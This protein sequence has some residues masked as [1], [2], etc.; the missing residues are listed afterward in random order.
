MKVTSIV[1]TLVVVALHARLGSS[2]PLSGAL[3]V[4]LLLPLITRFRVELRGAAQLAF[5]VAAFGAALALSLTFA[6]RSAAQLNGLSAWWSSL[7]VA[8]VLLIASRAFVVAPLGGEALNLAIATFGL[9]ACGGT[10]SGALYPTVIVIFVAT[11]LLARRSASASPTPMTHLFREHGFAVTV[12]AA[13]SFGT[14][15]AL[16]SVLPTAHAWTIG[17]ILEARPPAVGVGGR[18]WLGSMRGLL[19]SPES[20]L[21]VRGDVEL[22]R[23]VVFDS[24]DLGRWSR[25][26]SSIEPLSTPRSLSGATVVE[27]ESIDRTPR[28][29][30]TALDAEEIALSSGV[31]R[32]DRLGNLEAVEAYPADRTFLR[33]GSSGLTS[34]APPGERDLRVPARTAGRLRALAQAWADQADGDDAKLHALERALLSEYRYSLDFERSP[35]RDPIEEFLFVS[36]RGHCEYFASAFALLA[37]SLGI[38]ARVVT[39]YRVVERNPLTGDWVVRRRDA[40]AWVEVWTGRWTAVD[41]TPAGDGALAPARTTPLLLAIFDGLGALGGRFLIW[42]DGLSVAEAVA[43]PLLLVFLGALVRWARTRRDSYARSRHGG[44]AP[45]PAF[46]R[47]LDALDRAGLAGKSNDTVEA[48]G[49]RVGESD[50]PADLASACV[51][52]LGRY[53]AYRY[54]GRGERRDLESRLDDLARQVRRRR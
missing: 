27:I 41:P 8:C 47:L 6:H 39:G 18:L 45:L 9:M 49:R 12:F 36:K 43:A 28:R 3:A 38:P 14:A 2:L 51:D 17:R 7:A 30:F 20:V 37:R 10:K 5:G 13:V 48:V 29:Y 25:D 24:Y 42:L 33:R 23:G 19:D 21:R 40:H 52:A 26:D 34:I 46:S 35:Y 53:A 54:G 50:L 4:L 15:F 31:G 22:L 1:P 11:A 44:E 16:S 32:V